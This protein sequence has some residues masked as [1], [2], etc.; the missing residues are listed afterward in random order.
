MN[1]SLKR[2][3][4]LFLLPTLIAFVIGFIIPFCMGLYLSFCEY[5]T[6]E[7]PTFVGFANYTRVFTADSGF[8]YSFGV[9]HSRK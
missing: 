4:P 7:E 5:I 1:N 9:F 3:F 8:W 6:I 2:W